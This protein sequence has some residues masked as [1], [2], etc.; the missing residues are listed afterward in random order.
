MNKATKEQGHIL[1]QLNLRVDH[2]ILL[3]INTALFNSSMHAVSVIKNISVG[4]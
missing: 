4:L 1:N 2:M 3:D